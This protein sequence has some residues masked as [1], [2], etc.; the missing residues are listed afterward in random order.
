MG[1]NMNN[2]ILL[3][4]FVYILLIFLKWKKLSHEGFENNGEIVQ[5]EIPDVKRPF[6]NFYDNSGNRLNI[7]GISKPFIR[8][9]F[10]MNIKSTN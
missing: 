8:H 4:V 7:I 2:I 3:G 9:N 1:N 5:P 10:T 6:V